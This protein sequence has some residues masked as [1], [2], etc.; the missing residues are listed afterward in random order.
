MLKEKPVTRKE[1]IFS[2]Q[3]NAEMRIRRRKTIEKLAEIR[4][5][6]MDRFLTAMDHTNL[7]STTHKKQ[8]KMLHQIEEQD[9]GAQ[10]IPTVEAPKLPKTAFENMSSLTIDENSSDLSAHV[11]Y[12]ENSEFNF[13]KLFRN[14]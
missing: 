10:T 7:E 5:E 1:D 14:L 6:P 13:I 3:E 11:Q 4:A 8:N 12:D 2:K 9:S